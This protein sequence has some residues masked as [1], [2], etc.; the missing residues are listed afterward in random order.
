MV[1]ES[2]DGKVRQI[3]EVALHLHHAQSN[4]IDDDDEEDQAG[5]QQQ[6]PGHHHEYIEIW[7]QKYCHEA[8][9]SLLVRSQIKVLSYK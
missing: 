6:D 9:P 8:G 2:D 4:L 3:A 5:D 1:K 7:I